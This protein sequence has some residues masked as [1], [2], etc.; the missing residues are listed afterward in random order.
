MASASNVLGGIVLIAASGQ[1][2]TSD[3]TNTERI[4]G[5]DKIIGGKGHDTMA[6]GAGKDG[7]TLH[8]VNLE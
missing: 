7:S 6:G 3:L 8:D 2:T 5:N 4:I 1:T